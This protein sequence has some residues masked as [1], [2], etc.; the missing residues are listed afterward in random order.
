LIA[1]TLFEDSFT[2]PFSGLL[3]LTDNEE[4]GRA[5]YD[6]DLENYTIELEPFAGPIF[7]FYSSLVLPE[8]FIAEVQAIYSGSLENSFGVLFRVQDYDQFYSFQIGGHGHYLVEKVDGDE[9]TLLKD[10]TESPAI[11]FEEGAVNEMTVVANGSTY[12]LYVNDVELFSFTDDR[13]RGGSI[14]LLADNFDEEAGILLEFDDLVVG[15]PDEVEIPDAIT[16]LADDFSVVE[17]GL[18]NEE[19]ISEWGLS[20]YDAD[21]GTY[22]IRAMPPSFVFQYYYGLRLPEQ[23]EAEVSTTFSGS[24]ENSYGMLFQV[25]DWENFYLFHISSDGT[26]LVESAMGEEGATVIDWTETTSINRAEGEINR[27]RVEAD[28]PDYSLFINGD[29]VASFSDD[30]HQGG[31]IG[32]FADNPGSDQEVEAIFDD[33]LVSHALYQDIQESGSAPAQ[34][35][36]DGD[37]SEEDGQPVDTV[38]P[39][40]FIDDF[41]DPGSGWTD[42]DERQDWGYVGYAPEEGIYYFDLEPDT[43]I[44][45]AYDDIALPMR[46]DITVSAAHLDNPEN[47]YGLLFQVNDSGFYAFTISGIGE[48]A[49]ELLLDDEWYGLVDWTESSAINVG[50]GEVNELYVEADGGQ[51]QL[52]VNGVE[53]ASFY[54]DNLTDGS[55]G[56]FA[57]SWEEPMVVGV[58]ELM[59]VAYE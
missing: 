35:E 2:S 29:Q 12:S 46:F 1:A 30:M 38:E 26:F 33:L 9:Y 45:E 51:Y 11:M 21:D 40:E 39:Y 15:F 55:V 25:E 23:F 41:S 31:S 19:D 13:F 20:Y 42:M 57:G 17:G 22:R 3:D 28:G 16:I 43:F 14:G 49:L 32:F 48:F 53:V 59:I 56:F 47:E 7:D 18:P 24:S 36:G 58:N 34:D 8:D 10:W 5:F 52:Y 27:L 37:G 4:W 50:P 54:D 44:S 6:R